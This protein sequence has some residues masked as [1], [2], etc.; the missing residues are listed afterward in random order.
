MCLYIIQISLGERYSSSEFL[1][2]YFCFLLLEL[3]G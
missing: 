2:S 3:K 1:M